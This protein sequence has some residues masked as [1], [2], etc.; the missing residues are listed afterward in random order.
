MPSAVNSL[1]S[2]RKM[3]RAGSRGSHSLTPKKPLSYYMADRHPP[4]RAVLPWAR[5]VQAGEMTGAGVPVISRTFVMAGHHVE[6]ARSVA[7]QLEQA[8]RP[9]AI[10]SRRDH[11]NTRLPDRRRVRAENAATPRRSFA[12]RFHPAA[13]RWPGFARRIMNACCAPFQTTRPSSL[14][15]GSLT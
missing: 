13:C 11:L 1:Y 8:R 12:C 4:V 3:T 6:Q 10:K 2:A 7:S 15:Q 14:Y 9:V 5:G